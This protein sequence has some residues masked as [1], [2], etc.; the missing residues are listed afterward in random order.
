M[1]LINCTVKVAPDI[2][3]HYLSDIYKLLHNNSYQKFL[4]INAGI[5]I[6]IKHFDI[7]G[8]ITMTIKENKTAFETIID[9]EY[10]CRKYSISSISQFAQ[11]I[12]Y[13]E[14]IPK[15]CNYKYALDRE[16]YTPY[17]ENTVQMVNNHRDKVFVKKLKP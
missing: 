11:R 1:N 13:K 7:T 3:E 14:L 12:M 9:G 17:E 10:I 8:L 2:F 15:G 4:D 6:D 16:D 5:S